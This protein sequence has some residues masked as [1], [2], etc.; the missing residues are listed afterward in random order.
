MEQKKIA[1][2]DIDKTIYNGYLIVPLAEYFFKEHAISHDIVGSL[3]HDLHLYRSKQINYETT[4]ESF[5]AHLAMGL[6]NHQPDS[7]LR[8]TTTFLGAEEG[9][10]FF[11][12]TEPLMKLLKRSYDIYL[13][14][15]E[16]QCVGEAVAEYFSLS[17]YV[18][19]EMEVV[20]GMFTGNIRRSLAKKEGKR[21]AIGHI[22]SHHPH[23]DSLAFG[24]SEGDID[25]LSKVAH[26]FCINATEGLLDVACT[27][28]WHI[29]TPLT[30]I[31]EVK[32]LL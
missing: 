28:G 22:L 32:K 1:L 5:N 26:A 25:M 23:E 11:P 13:V 31:E 6:K 17:G 18:S 14:T 7:I 3:Y 12:F 29:V 30:I 27:Q 20:N 24:D 21:D 2:F 9:C 4:V 19:T 8:T 10:N 15:G 16:V